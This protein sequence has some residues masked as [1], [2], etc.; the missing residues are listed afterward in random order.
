MCVWS[1]VASWEGGLPSKVVDRCDTE[2]ANIAALGD[3]SP[4]KEVELGFPR[5]GWVVGQGGMDKDENQPLTAAAVPK[6]DYNLAYIIF[7]LLGLGFLL[8]W[9]SFISAVDYFDVLYP[10]SHVDRVFSLAYMI[11]CFVFLLALTFYGQKCSSWLRIN[12]GLIVFLGVFAFV[13]VMDE[14]WITGNKGSKTTHV[15]TIGAASVLGL[16]DAL[17]Q[18]SLIGS[19]GELPE[20]YMQALVAG[21]AASGRESPWR[22]TLL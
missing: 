17:V 20:R 14:V 3:S 18:G 11:P 5:M 22:W 21:T 16:C 15:L 10:H 7:F 12:V 6:D 13:P 4:V 2:N 8:P 9:N 1:A 19:A